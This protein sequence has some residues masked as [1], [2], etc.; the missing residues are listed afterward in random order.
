MPQ[1]VSA[2]RRAAGARALLCLAFAAAACGKDPVE[3]LR[4]TKLETQPGTTPQTARVASLVPVS[5]AVRVLDQHGNPMAGVEVTFDA[6]NGSGTI[7][8]ATVDTTD[9]L[10]MASIAAWTLGTAAGAQT[11][12]ATAGDASATFTVLATAG[13]ATQFTRNSTEQQSAVV[14]TA[15]ATPP[16]VLL[17][18]QYGNPV[19]GVQVTF[20]VGGGTATIPGSTT[21][22]VV[23]QTNASG[24]ATVPGWV[25]GQAAGAYGLFAITPG[26]GALQF[27]ATA[28]AGAASQV[29][30]SLT[31]SILSIGDVSIVNASLRDQFGNTVPGGTFTFTSSNE[32]VAT[33]STAG[34]VRAVAKGTADITVRS[35]TFSRVVSVIVTDIV[36][37]QLSRP[38]GVAISS[39]GV[40]YVTQPSSAQVA[41]AT[42]P[43]TTFTSTIPVGSEA[44]AVAF[45]PN[46]ASAY[47]SNLGSG[48]VS[49]IDV[50][51]GTNVGNTL[52]TG[53]A[54]QVVAV[55]SDGSRVFAGT[56]G[57]NVVVLN[58][59]T[60]AVVTNIATGGAINGLVAHPSQP[61]LYASSQ[62]GRV[63]E[64]NTTTNTIARTFS[65][66]GF[67]QNIVIT[68]TGD[69]LWVANESGATKVITVATGASV[70]AG[71]SRAFGIAIAP[72]NSQV[73]VTSTATNTL[74]I[75]NR[76]TRAVTQEQL[77]A[78]GG[79]PRRVA[80][81][82]AGDVVVIAN[83]AGSVTFLPR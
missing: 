82:P 56:S 64:I 30:A 18:D 81:S 23:V 2:A 44:S 53:G 67:L 9:A 11:L 58:A 17:R 40:V 12:T 66:G 79:S 54:P 74:Y 35:G 5:P 4:P 70:D 45:S 57:G 10:G 38:Y 3:P 43:A 52:V 60:R 55:S 26:L 39:Q 59:A 15:V 14:N 49:F 83:E 77:L 33:V 27:T 68:S 36:N 21:G 71:G 8:G 41:R 25:L 6:A 1:L 16:S 69:E 51:A 62:D 22:S 7:T 47:V 31:P 20:S 72:D 32:A 63:F 48:S 13:N 61:L 24:V 46:G 76:A 50:A 42:L 28:T 75:V 19:Q 78:G 73:Y 29:F 65:P 34:E 80:V 37:R